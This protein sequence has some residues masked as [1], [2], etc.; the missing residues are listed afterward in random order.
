MDSGTFSTVTAGPAGSGTTTSA[1]LA[2]ILKAMT[3]ATNFFM[4]RLKVY[5]LTSLKAPGTCTSDYTPSNNDQIYGIS[6]SD[7]HIYVLYITNKDITYNANGASCLVEGG[8]LPDSTLR[9]GR[10][11]MGRII[12]NTYSLTDQLTALT[13][14]VF[15]SITGTAIH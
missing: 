13:N 11:T 6:A 10:P 7:L 4:V 9:K 3:V 14:V 12:F 5:P 8:T 2:F 15:Q 1:N